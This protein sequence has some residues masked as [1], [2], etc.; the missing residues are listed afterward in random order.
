MQVI[1][2]EKV[3]N[4]GDL[5]EVVNVRNGYARNF[6]IPRGIARRATPEAVQEIEQQRAELERAQQERLAA[7]QALGNQLAELRVEILQKAGVDGRLFGSVTNMDITEALAEKGFER[8]QRAQIRL[9][10]GPLTAVGE[11]PV[12][13]S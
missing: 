12:A 11:Y 7:A 13:I 6:L 3:A 2:L 10:D 9:P 8:M 1:L 5:G 4:L